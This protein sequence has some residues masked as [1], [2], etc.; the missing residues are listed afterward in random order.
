MV[1]ILHMFNSF[2]TSLTITI[3]GNITSA[4]LILIL[5]MILWWQAALEIV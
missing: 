3:F 1:V 4:I 2:I 5:I